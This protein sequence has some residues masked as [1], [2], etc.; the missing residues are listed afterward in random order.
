MFEV[1]K[2]SKPKDIYSLP[3]KQGL[4]FTIKEILKGKKQLF[5]FH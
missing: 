1:A 3:A 4:N 5:Y 2:K